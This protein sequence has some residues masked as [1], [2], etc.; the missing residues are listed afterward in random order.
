[1]GAMAVAGSHAYIANFASTPAIIHCSIGPSGM[2]SGCGDTGLNGLEDPE[3]LTAHGSTLY[4]G[5]S[6]SPRVRKCH[7]RDDGALDACSSAGL[8]DSFGLAAEDIR[9]VDSTAYILHLDEE[10]V[11]K[12]LVGTDGGFSG[13]TS[14]GA[15]GLSTPFGFAITGKHMYIANWSNNNIQRCTMD[16][17]GSLADCMDAAADRFSSPTQIAVRGSSVYVTSSAGGVTHCT[18]TSEGLLTACRLSAAAEPI[19]NIVLR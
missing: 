7:I 16:T 9:V 17:D 3:G 8:P 13:C 14:A 10:Q 15:S 12:C 5:D 6:S 18:R 2:L 11:S 4:I 19:Y 1:M